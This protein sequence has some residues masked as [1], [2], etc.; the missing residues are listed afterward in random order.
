MFI[1]INILFI[2]TLKQHILR[3]CK[4]WLLAL[5]TCDLILAFPVTYLAKTSQNLLWSDAVEEDAIDW[6]TL[7]SILPTLTDGVDVSA[8]RRHFVIG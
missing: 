1:S 2:F 6:S 7:L 4:R 8:G 5:V 3:R